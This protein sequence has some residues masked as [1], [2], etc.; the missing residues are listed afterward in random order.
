MCSGP[1]IIVL[2]PPPPF[3]LL[4]SQCVCV[5]VR[6][7]CAGVANPRDDTRIVI[8]ITIIINILH[9][10]ER[11]ELLLSLSF[12]AH[13]VPPPH[14]FPLLSLCVCVFVGGK[15][16]GAFVCVCVCVRLLCCYIERSCYCSRRRVPA[17][18]PY[19]MLTL[20]G[21]ALSGAS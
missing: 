7:R 21:R 11:P 4:L 15:G 9:C 13:I 2:S 10:W 12:W 18:E 3:F 19:P 20:L 16:E 1:I 8:I 14:S 5:C 17:E 6:V